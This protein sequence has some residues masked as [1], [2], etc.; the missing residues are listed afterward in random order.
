MLFRFQ[1]AWIFTTLGDLTFSLQK[2]NKE[3]FRNLFRRKQKLWTSMAK[4]GCGILTEPRSLWMIVM[5]HKYCKGRCDMNMFSAKYD[6]SNT[7][8]R[9]SE[10]AHEINWGGR[11]TV[12]WTHASA[13]SKPLIEL[14][15]SPIPLYEQHPHNGSLLGAWDMHDGGGIILQIIYQGKF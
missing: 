5:C 8:K 10:N 1:A 2:W 7:W 11:S 3:V 13:T 4:L 14:A 6:A 12:F 9:I 15:L